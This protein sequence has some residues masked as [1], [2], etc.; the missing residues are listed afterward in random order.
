MFSNQQAVT[1]LE[2]NIALGLLLLLLT[3]G[4]CV[5][6]NCRGDRKM[7]TLRCAIMLLCGKFTVSSFQKSLCRSLTLRSLDS[8]DAGDA[9]QSVCQSEVLAASFI[10]S[11]SRVW[12]CRTSPWPSWYI[13]VSNCGSP[14]RGRHLPPPGYSHDGTGHSQLVLQCLETAHAL[15]Q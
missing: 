10:P 11:S 6:S 3:T 12:L 2:E 13:A 1:E 7:C 15:V 5:Q 9:L 14:L 4:L 8:Q